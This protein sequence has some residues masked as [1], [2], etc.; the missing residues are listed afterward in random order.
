MVPNSSPRCF[1]WHIL[2][3]SSF[4]R[5]FCPRGCWLWNLRSYEMRLCRTG[6][7]DVAKPGGTLL[8]AGGCDAGARY[9][10]GQLGRGFHRRSGAPLAPLWLCR[11]RPACAGA[12]FPPGKRAAPSAWSLECVWSHAAPFLPDPRPIH[13]AHSRH[14]DSP[15]FTKSNDDH[16]SRG[17]T[18]S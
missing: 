4:A 18:G 2:L 14:P 17:P 8:G 16:Q 5:A 15:G 6:I 7:G 10:R 11:G 9:A 13:R 1:F 12:A 3:A